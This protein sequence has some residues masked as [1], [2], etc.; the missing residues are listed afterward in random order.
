M[1]RL[2]QAMASRLRA[3]AQLIDGQEYMHSWWHKHSVRQMNKY[4]DATEAELS[5]RKQATPTR[6]ASM[7]SIRPLALDNHGEL[8]FEIQIDDRVA[9]I[10]LSREMWDA[11]AT[12]WTAK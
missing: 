12:Y 3:L 9:S 11:F 8:E 5:R 4:I 6:G 7:T 1:R 10:F 2:R